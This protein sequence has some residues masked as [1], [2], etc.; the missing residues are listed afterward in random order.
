MINSGRGREGSRQECKHKE[1]V[2]A[3]RLGK[4]TRQLFRQLG[5]VSCMTASQKCLWMLRGDRLN[6]P[7]RLECYPRTDAWILLCFAVEY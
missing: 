3:L 1:V 7:N 2:I 5:T 4:V 6:I